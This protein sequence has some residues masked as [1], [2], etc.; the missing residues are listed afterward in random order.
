[1]GDRE[2]HVAQLVIPG[3]P[4]ALARPRVARGRM[5]DPRGNQIA[6]ER[7]RQL[8]R[9]SGY[10]PFDADAPLHLAVH[11]FFPRPRSHYVGRDVERGRLRPDAPRFVTRRPD[12][13]N[14]IKLV[15]DA[16]QGLAFHDDSRIV[17]LDASKR[18]VDPPL[19]QTLVTL[20][21]MRPYPPP[22][23]QPAAQAVRLAA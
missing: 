18:W 14:I 2:L 3:E 23:E 6:K 13:D 9:R 5:Y 11:C 17:W 10:E 8:W 7:I 4:Q 12:L 20:R 1:M 21:E 22:V 19:A 16:L 15:A